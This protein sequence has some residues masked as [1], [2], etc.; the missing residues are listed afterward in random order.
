M[1]I[2]DL[3]SEQLQEISRQFL[4]HSESRVQPQANPIQ[5]ILHFQHFHRKK[6]FTFFMRICR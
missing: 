4:F 2:S 5:M 6:T 1:Q 3:L